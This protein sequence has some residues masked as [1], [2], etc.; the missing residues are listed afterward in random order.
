ED[1]RAAAVETFV[2]SASRQPARWV[3][4][5]F[6]P[7]PDVRRRALAHLPPRSARSLYLLADPE[8]G[9]AVRAALAGRA[10]P[11]LG[12]RG[13]PRLIGLRR[14]GHLTPAEA[15][16]PLGDVEVRAVLA[17][18]A[19]GRARPPQEIDQLLR[20]LSSAGEPLGSDVLDELLKILLAAAEPGREALLLRW[21]EGL[22]GASE[23][24]RRRVRS[25]EHTSE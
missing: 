25:E 13:L 6:D 18:A 17:F 7:R 4:A 23:P 11:R 14:S 2:A 24:M 16:L 9:D 22:L 12:G 10:R 19:T 5:L 20:S 3:H 15:A 21:R 8:N 1:V